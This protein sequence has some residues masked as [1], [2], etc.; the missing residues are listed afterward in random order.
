MLDVTGNPEEERHA[1]FFYQ[2]WIP[3]AVSRYF[4]S[5][6]QQKRTELE[7]LLGLNK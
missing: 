3:E 2:P 1:E 5:K 7:H 6:I 4:Y